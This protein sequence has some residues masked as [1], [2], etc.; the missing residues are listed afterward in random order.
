MTFLTAA[1][2][3]AAGEKETAGEGSSA[4]QPK[5][6][7]TAYLFG[8]PPVGYEEVYGKVN[9]KLE[10]MFNAT[11]K[12]N[13]L[14]WGDW[15]KK[16][17][18]ILASGEEF[19]L[20][21][22]ASWAYF[23]NQAQKGVFMELDGLLPRHAPSLYKHLP[24]AAKEQAKVNGKMY[25]VPFTDVSPRDN[26]FLVRGDLLKKYG[27]D[28]IETLDDF[29]DFL[30][31]VLENEPGVVPYHMGTNDIG[32]LCSALAFSNDWTFDGFSGSV[33]SKITSDF[34]NVEEAVFSWYLTPEYADFVRQMKVWGEKG[35]WT[36]NALT[37]KVVAKESMLYGKSAAT[38]T[39]LDDANNV[40]MQVKD[41]H[42][43][44][45]LTWF[46]MAPDT[47]FENP[48]YRVN[49][50]SIPASSKNPERA[51]QVL[52][53]LTLN[54][55]LYDLCFYGIKGKHY[56]LTEKGRIVTG[57]AGNY[58]GEDISIW[59]FRNPDY[60]RYPVEI[61]PGYIENLEF[62]RKN[63]VSN[64]LAA[65]SFNIENIKS[66]IAAIKDIDD[67]YSDPLVVG[68]VDVDEG[69]KQLEEKLKQAGIDK[70]LKEARSQCKAYF[71]N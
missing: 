17:P 42:P 54:R 36:K 67:Q 66:E 52:Q 43:E 9:E 16:Y 19:D 4:G 63:A 3:F 26:G 65:F 39:T 40:Y 31:K 20:A 25:M 70:V 28:K 29:G 46:P 33:F 32:N 30:Q 55:D 47:A 41:D 68:I 64:K 15:S 27:M 71:N 12:L 23:V 49:G 48:S 53:E 7:L 21:Y 51:L 56:E 50:F 6:E 5:V 59:G 37:N 18:L 24:E 8:E 13:F 60:K 1:A 35:Y 10:E 38:I 14:S 62:M 57:P 22:S 69:L 11:L 2:V 58:A 44:W 61:M 34:S 45:K